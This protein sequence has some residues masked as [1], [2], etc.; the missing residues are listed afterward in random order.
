MDSV[1]RDAQLSSSL[2]DAEISQLLSVQLAK[3]VGYLGP[4][5]RLE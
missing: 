4:Q 2:F 5:V 3:S 1:G